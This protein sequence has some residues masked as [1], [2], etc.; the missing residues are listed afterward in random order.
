MRA[1]I[2]LGAPGAGKGTAA[3]RVCAGTPF[4]HFSTGDMLRE[5]VKQGTPVG[6]VSETYMQRGELVPDQIMM[7]VVEARIAQDPPDAAYLFDGFPR[8]VRQ[9]EL[10]EAVLVRR[11]GCLEH[12]LFLDAPRE[13]LLQRL[14]GRRICRACGANFHMVNMPPR[15]AGRCDACGGALYQRPDDQESTVLSRLD[16]FSRKTEALIAHYETLG[17]LRRID[18]GGNAERLVADVMRVLAAA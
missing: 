11:Q 17:L 3:E 13:V 14:G 9:A 15:E 7:E 10:L 4:R 5:A 2:L 8:T 6:R 16:V 1:I 18:A 12:V